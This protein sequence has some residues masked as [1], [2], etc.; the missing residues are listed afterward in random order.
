MEAGCSDYLCKPVDPRALV[1]AVRRAIAPAA[2]AITELHGPG[3]DPA[4]RAAAG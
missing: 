1:A 2:T 3:A 4:P